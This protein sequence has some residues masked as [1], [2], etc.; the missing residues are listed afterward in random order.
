MSAALIKNTKKPYDV[1]D[2]LQASITKELD[3]Y[4][5]YSEAVIHRMTN[6]FAQYLQSS[7]DLELS[8]MLVQEHINL[9][10]DGILLNK[11]QSMHLGLLNRIHKKQIAAATK[12]KN[13]LKKL[14]TMA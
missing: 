9:E 6:D 1:P 14:K 7:K 12:I 10:Y 13:Q 11:E 3:A 4:T 5:G 8:K 2:K